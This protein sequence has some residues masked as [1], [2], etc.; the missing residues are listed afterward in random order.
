MQFL[1]KSIGQRSTLQLQSSKV[2]FFSWP[3]PFFFVT[4][5]LQIV[6][7]DKRKN[8]ETAGIEENYSNKCQVYCKFFSGLTA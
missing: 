2:Y 7:H 8:V 6:L 4:Q 5:R 1:L 3:H